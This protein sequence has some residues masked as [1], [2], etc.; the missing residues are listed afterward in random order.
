M[1]IQAKTYRYRSDAHVRTLPAA[2]PPAERTASSHA[3]PW[4]ERVDGHLRQ[5]THGG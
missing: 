5:G 1:A 2:T 4:L 3:L